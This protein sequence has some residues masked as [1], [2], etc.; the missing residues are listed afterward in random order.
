[1]KKFLMLAVFTV[2]FSVHAAD[3]AF[4]SGSAADG[5]WAVA[6][7]STIRRA[8][9][10]MEDVLQQVTTY[11]PMMRWRAYYDNEAY[12]VTIYCKNWSS[13]PSFSGSGSEPFVRAMAHARRGGN[14]C[15]FW[16][17]ELQP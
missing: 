6:H 4:C 13:N 5:A 16:V 14:G 7:A 8:C 1:M 9:E 3:T 11:P 2:G 12:R 15:M 10:K 17:K